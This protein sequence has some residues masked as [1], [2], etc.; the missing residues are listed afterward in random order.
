MSDGLWGEAADFVPVFR[1][2]SQFGMRPWEAAEVPL[3]WFVMADI[4]GEALHD[5]NRE[6]RGMGLPELRG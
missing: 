2:A 4:Y 6:R 5:A 1:R 3:A